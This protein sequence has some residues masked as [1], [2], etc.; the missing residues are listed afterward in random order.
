MQPRLYFSDLV[1]LFTTS[2]NQLF[3]FFLEIDATFGGKFE[4]FQVIKAVNIDD[5]NIAFNI[6]KIAKD[7]KFTVRSNFKEMPN[8]LF[9]SIEKIVDEFKS[10]EYKDWFD[11]F[12]DYFDIPQV[13]YLISLI[14]FLTCKLLLAIPL[15]EEIH[16]KITFKKSEIVNSCV[17]LE[18][19][20]NEKTQLIKNKKLEENNKEILTVKINESI[21][22]LE[23]NAKKKKESELE[24]KKEKDRLEHDRDICSVSTRKYE[25]NI[26]KKDRD[27]QK[28]EEELSEKK[29]KEFQQ[30]VKYM[31]S[32]TF[33]FQIESDL[34]IDDTFNG[35]VKFDNNSNKSNKTLKPANFLIKDI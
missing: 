26:G 3:T 13:Q 18:K 35:K 1:S 32:N 5:T 29:S 12:K 8:Y 22:S 6:D 30:L 24:T 27:M 4:K 11:C 21:N 2:S 25:T 19:L 23:K 17:K 15:N 33:E 34:I 20:K 16:N 9:K 10:M 7:S 28:L 31:I 14:G